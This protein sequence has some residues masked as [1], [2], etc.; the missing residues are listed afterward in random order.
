MAASPLAAL[1]PTALVTGA[2]N[3]LGRAFAEMLLAEGVRVWGTA[4]SIERL[5][6]LA[7]RPGLTPVA[8]DL[9]DAAAAEAA[10]LDAAP[11]PARAAADLCAA[12]LRRRTGIVRSGSFFQAV[13]APF[14]ARFTT[15]R[16][17]NAIMKRYFGL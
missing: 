13:L 14:L 7:A 16:I 15:W 3:G 6:T 1:V 17:R 5:D 11:L 2:S 10:Y 4:R 12:I 8:L 9:R